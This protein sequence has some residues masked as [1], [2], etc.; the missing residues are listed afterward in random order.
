LPLILLRNQSI[1]QAICN[2]NGDAFFFGASTFKALAI[3][4]KKD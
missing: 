4:V 1:R 2:N 3:F